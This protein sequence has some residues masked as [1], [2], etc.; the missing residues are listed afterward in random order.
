MT[1]KIF[2][3]YDGLVTFYLQCPFKRQ[4]KIALVLIGKIPNPKRL[5]TVMYEPS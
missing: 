4:F 1:Y 2:L 5:K 3:A